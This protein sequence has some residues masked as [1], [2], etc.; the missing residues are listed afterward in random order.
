MVGTKAGY[1][2]PTAELDGDGTLLLVGAGSDA[3]GGSEL[4]AQEGGTDQFPTLPDNAPEVVATLA[5]IADA[6]AT[7]SVHD[8]STGGLAVTLAELITADAGADV[9]V[10]DAV[11]LFDETPG[12]TVVETTGP[13]SVTEAFEGVAPVTRLGT[14]TDDGSLSL[15]VGGEELTV[16]ADR[17]AAL[18][19]VLG[20]TLD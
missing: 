11:S 3:L 9:A 19:G 4:L 15:D 13:E 2:A 17:V 18:R 1:D 14:A 16:G 8:V 12:R 7:L 10:D 5:D 6:D 20:E